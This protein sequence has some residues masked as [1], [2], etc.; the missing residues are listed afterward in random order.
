MNFLVLMVTAFSAIF[1]AR[2]TKRKEHKYKQVFYTQNRNYQLEKL[3]TLVGDLGFFDAWW[4][5]LVK[6]PAEAEI[7]KN[8]NQ[9]FR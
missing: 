5:V 1:S 9:G 4:G 7:N 2:T 3:I 6:A 8:D